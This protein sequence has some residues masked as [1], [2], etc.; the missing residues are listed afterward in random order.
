MSVLLISP[1]HMHYPTLFTRRKIVLQEL[2]LAQLMAAQNA[3]RCTMDVPN[4]VWPEELDRRRIN[5]ERRAEY[6]DRLS[7][8]LYCMG[9]YQLNLVFDV[10]RHNGRLPQNMWELLSVTGSVRWDVCC[11]VSEQDEHLPE[12][13]GIYAT[14]VTSVAMLRDELNRDALLPYWQA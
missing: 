6:H 12:S 11:L 13:L 14:V 9:R 8:V 2:V 1:V 10:R 5:G 7:Y 3:E 4:T